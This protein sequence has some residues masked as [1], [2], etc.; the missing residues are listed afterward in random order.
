M[1]SIQGFSCGSLDSFGTSLNHDIS[2]L[3]P[4][5]TSIKVS[6]HWKASKSLALLDQTWVLVCFGPSDFMFVLQVLGEDRLYLK[7][8]MNQWFVL[9]Y[10]VYEWTSPTTVM[11]TDGWM[12]KHLRWIL[13]KNGT[14]G[15][16]KSVFLFWM[17]GNSPDVLWGCFFQP[18]G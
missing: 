3:S 8:S 7:G 11:K 13:P 15:F 1:E 18:G 14:V 12:H 5:A 4:S 6:F 9:I 17:C 2:S 16:N 10:L